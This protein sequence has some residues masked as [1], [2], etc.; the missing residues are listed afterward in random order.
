MSKSPKNPPQNYRSDAFSAIHETM[1]GLH[2][3]GAVSKQTLREF[4]AACLTSALGLPTV[5][6]KKG[7]VAIA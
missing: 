1:E 4:D 5:V 3:I 7:L 2:D 6:Q